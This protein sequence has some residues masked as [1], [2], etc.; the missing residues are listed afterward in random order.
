LLGKS[1]Q[2]IEKLLEALMTNSREGECD[3]D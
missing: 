3:N 1:L 2:R